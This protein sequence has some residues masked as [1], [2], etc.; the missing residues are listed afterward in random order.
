MSNRHYAAVVLLA[1][2]VLAD[3]DLI[4]AG[5]KSSYTDERAKV[6]QV[7]QVES[8]GHRFIAYVVTWGGAHVAVSD[9][10]AK[11]RHREGD[12]IRFLAQRIELP[13]AVKTLN[14]TLSEP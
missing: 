3:C 2:G 5:M 8:S 11:S 10:L 4:R 9:P 6:E 13:G 12:E 7:L 1:V 14:F